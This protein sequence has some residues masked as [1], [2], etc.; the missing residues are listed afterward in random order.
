[1]L[2][3]TVMHGAVFNTPVHIALG[4]QR[5]T[6]G[7]SGVGSLMQMGCI[8]IIHS[9]LFERSS[10]IILTNLPTRLSRLSGRENIPIYTKS[11]FSITLAVPN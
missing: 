7:I 4:R 3:F 8:G 10:F 6:M 1:M 11:S 9:C 2:M 5:G